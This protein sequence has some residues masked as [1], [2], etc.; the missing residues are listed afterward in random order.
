MANFNKNE[1][2]YVPKNSVP[3]S[4]RTHNI[5]ITDINCC[6]MFKEV[7]TVYCVIIKNV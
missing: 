7:I 6:M 1:F 3:T 5:Y 4:Q 2:I